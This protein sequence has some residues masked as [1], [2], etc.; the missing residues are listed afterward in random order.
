MGFPTLRLDFSGI[1]D[2]I[3]RVPPLDA[4]PGGIADVREA[5][6]HLTAEYGTRQF[7]LLGLCSGARHAHHVALADPRVVGTIM[8]D[9]PAYPTVRSRVMQLLDRLGDPLQLLGGAKRRAIG[10]FQPKT[11]PLTMIPDEGEAFFPETPRRDQ[12]A[13]AL[14]TLASRKVNQLYVYTG[15]TRDYRYEGQLRGAFQ[16]LDLVSVVTER[17]LARADHLFFTKPER[18]ELLAIVSSW[19]REHYP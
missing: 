5:M 3:P 9:P 12:M 6:D 4:I 10:L 8:L 14:Q 2:S 7:L 13:S 15:E 18:A 11:K 17:R 16:E 19:L 1:G